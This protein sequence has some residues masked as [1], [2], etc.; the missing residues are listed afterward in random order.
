M[1]KKTHTLVRQLQNL[2]YQSGKQKKIKLINQHA[3]H[4]EVYIIYW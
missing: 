1:Y 4:S 3:V 2:T